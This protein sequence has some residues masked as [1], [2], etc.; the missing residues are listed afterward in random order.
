VTRFSVRHAF[1][2]HYTVQNAGGCAHQ[3][4]WIPAED[5]PDFNRNIVG[6]IEVCC[7]VSCRASDPGL[8]HLAALRKAR[9]L[10]SQILRACVG[11]V[12]REREA[13]NGAV[14][15]AVKA[16]VEELTRRFPIY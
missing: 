10:L 3:E 9:E 4:D 8:A 14:E 13:E 12:D 15:A 6:E 7:G 5:L 11:I 2:A 16:Q 1:L